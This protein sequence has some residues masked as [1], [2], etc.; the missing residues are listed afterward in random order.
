MALFL[1]T[2]ALVKLFDPEPGSEEVAELVRAG[3]RVTV[4][5]L[6][7]HEFTSAIRRK[8]REGRLSVAQADRPREQ[9]RSAFL[10]GAD[11]VGLDGPVSQ[12]ALELLDTHSDK[13]LRVL[14]AVQ[15]A[16]CLSVPGSTLVLG[17]RDL[18]RAAESEGVTTRLVG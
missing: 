1:D 7:P 18:A 5:A 9:F 3:G 13:G 10:P 12:R 6:T 17:D 14:D 11:V 15:L 8:T 16:C 2:S 4:G